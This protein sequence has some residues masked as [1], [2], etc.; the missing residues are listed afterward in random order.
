MFYEYMCFH[1][2][3]WMICVSNQV[4]VIFQNGYAYE[5][6]MCLAEYPLAFY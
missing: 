3:S 1:N 4:A 2:N 6:F 5:N